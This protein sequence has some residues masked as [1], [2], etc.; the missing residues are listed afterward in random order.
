VSPRQIAGRVVA[1][2]GGGRGILLGLSESLRGSGV[3][4]SVVMPGLVRNELAAGCRG[5]NTAGT[6]ADQR[7]VYERRIEAR[8]SK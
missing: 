8:G 2:T 3:D 5:R 7:A 4:L 1:V 6:T